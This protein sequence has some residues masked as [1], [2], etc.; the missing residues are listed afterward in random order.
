ML[1]ELCVAV[2]TYAS[3]GRWEHQQLSSGTGI[4]RIARSWEG[5]N[6]AEMART[7]LKVCAVPVVDSFRNNSSLFEGMEDVTL[8]QPNRF[9]G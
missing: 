2:S 6:I 7:C 3:S 1:T 8:S 4:T 9:D 5:G